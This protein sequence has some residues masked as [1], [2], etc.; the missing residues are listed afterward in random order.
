MSGGHSQTIAVYLGYCPAFDG[1]DWKSNKNIGGSEIAAANLVVEM[2]KLDPTLN[3]HVFGHTLSGSHVDSHGVVWSDMGYAHRF[4]EETPVIDMC[5]ISRYING[6]LYVPYLFRA[7]KIYV[8]VHDVYV[9]NAYQGIWMEHGATHL[10][11]NF[12]SRIDG[13]MCQSPWH[14]QKLEDAY[15]FMKGKIH[16]FP[17]GCD[18]DVLDI[19]KSSP[20]FTK[21]RFK[22][23]WAS[24]HD[25]DIENLVRLWPLILK[26]LPTATLVIA[27][28]QTPKTKD[29]VDAFVR[30]YASSVTF[31]GKVDHISLFKEMTTCDVW[32]YPTFFQETY[33]MLALEAQLAQ[34]VCIAYDQGSLKTTID[35]R[36]YIFT[37]SRDKP[38]SDD[39]LVRTLVDIIASQSRE[40]ERMVI[41]SNAQA[42][43]LQQTW[44]SRAKMWLDVLAL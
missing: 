14:L 34:L 36:G 26:C 33:C 15:P 27:G 4:F 24:H 44:A 20:T 40:N 25:R 37:F 13:F 6:L 16:I 39:A 8:W 32:F 1:D 28:D 23:V 43:A 18:K 17:N 19:V 7:K 29:V 35:D 2:K 41:R 30:E 11:Q 42:W 12:S 31:I 38:P 5:I 21:T 10:L 9:H 3:I 22:F